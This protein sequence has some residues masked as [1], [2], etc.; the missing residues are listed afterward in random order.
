VKVSNWGK[1]SFSYSLDGKSFTETSEEF[2]AEPGRW[3]GAKLGIFCSRETTT[4]DSGYADF[5]WFRV[6]TN[7]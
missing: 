6:E 2:V 5:D 1:C 3:I 7:Q 4:N